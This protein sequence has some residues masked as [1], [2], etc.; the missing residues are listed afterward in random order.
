[1]PKRL[2]REVGCNRIPLDRE[3]GIRDKS[4][5]RI[6]GVDYRQK[7]KR[8]RRAGRRP[9]ALITGLRKVIPDYGLRIPLRVEA[10]LDT[11]FPLPS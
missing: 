4:S 7:T 10:G 6:K 9:N 8:E 1:M 11:T 2:G 3:N 5:L